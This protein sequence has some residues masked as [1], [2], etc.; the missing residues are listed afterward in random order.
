MKMKAV[1]SKTTRTLKGL[2]RNKLA[3]WDKEERSEEFLKT[4]K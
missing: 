3:L 1:E 2:F 4:R